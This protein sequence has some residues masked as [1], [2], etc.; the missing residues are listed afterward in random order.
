MT[1]PTA[2]FGQTEPSPRRA[3]ASAARMKRRSAGRLLGDAVGTAVGSV[4]IRG[5]PPDKIAK[6]LRLAEVTVHR[7]EP[8]VGDLVEAR[9]RLHDETPD[10]IA[11]YIR[12]ARTLQLTHQ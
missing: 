10:H 6:I 1:Q 11:R 9:Q 4:A 2:G 5:D 3:S 7:S 12:F 8:D